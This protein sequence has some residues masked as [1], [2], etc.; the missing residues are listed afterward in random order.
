MGTY[1]YSTWADPIT[2]SGKVAGTA[3]GAG[4]AAATGTLAPVLVGGGR[5]LAAG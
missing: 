4:T 3:A 2:P 5:V 1:S